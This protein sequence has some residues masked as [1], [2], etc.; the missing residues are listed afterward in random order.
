MIARDFL[1]MKNPLDKIEKIKVPHKVK[2][3]LTEEEMSKIFNYL[4]EKKDLRGLALIHLF[5]SSACRISEVVQLN[6]DT[7]NFDDR[8]F[9]VKGKG[10]KERDCY[11]RKQAKEK[12]LEYLNSRTDNLPPL[13]ISIQMKRWSKRSIEHYVKV[14]IKEMGITKEITPHSFRHSSLT[15]Q[16]LNGALL[17]DLQLLAGHSSISTTQRTYTHVGLHEVSNKFDKFFDSRQY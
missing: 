15:N 6:R 4:E 8:K 16:R 5:Y 1:N 11:L 17:E 12:I 10:N 3:Y 2:D 14:L 9:K 7:L 13:F